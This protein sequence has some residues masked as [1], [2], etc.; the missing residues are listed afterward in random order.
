MPRAA[1]IGL[2]NA[3]RTVHQ[4]RN[5]YLGVR[6]GHAESNQA[7]ILMG[8]PVRGREAYG[9]TELGRTQVQQTAPLLYDQLSP[10]VHNGHEPLY[11]LCSPLLRARQTAELLQQDLSQRLPY[12]PALTVVEELCERGY[13]ALEGAPVNEWSKVRDGDALDLTRG[14]AGGESLLSFWT[15]VHSLLE[16]LERSSDGCTFVLVSHC[17]PLQVVHAIL[18]RAHS[19]HYSE[20]PQLSNAE[21]ITYRFA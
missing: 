6:H 5:T 8:C 4:L 10:Q 19:G 11:L 3:F 20:F 7:Q 9:L 15:R 18:S 2:P 1:G 12:A 14:Y 17:D 13:G 21:A 16:R